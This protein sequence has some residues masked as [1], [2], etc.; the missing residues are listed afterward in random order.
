MVFSVKAC[1]FPRFPPYRLS[2][3]HS[4][5]TAVLV[6]EL[7]AAASIDPHHDAILA[8]VV[9]WPMACKLENFSSSLG[10]CWDNIA[11]DEVIALE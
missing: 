4:G 8:A 7:D 1:S 11:L 5:A 3:P 2:K 9:K 10:S 6:D